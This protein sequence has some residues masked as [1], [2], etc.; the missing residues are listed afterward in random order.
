MTRVLLI[1]HNAFEV[2]LFNDGLLNLI[3]EF[4]SQTT[5]SM[6]SLPWKE[7]LSF[8][9]FPRWNEITTMSTN[10][11]TA[12]KL[13]SRVINSKV[14]RCT[15]MCHLEI[16]K[17]RFGCKM[18]PTGSGQLTISLCLFRPLETRNMILYVLYLVPT[19]P[20]ASSHKILIEQ[21]FSCMI[22]V[23]RPRF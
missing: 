18:F 7:M 11:L 3:D 4:D 23:F 6:M 14:W 10:S 5:W 19:I 16:R 21:S 2:W 13:L 15:Q 8:T 12:R 1:G 22:E 20:H 17:E 9:N